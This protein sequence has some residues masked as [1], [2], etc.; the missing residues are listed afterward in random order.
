MQNFI[1]FLMV[2]INDLISYTSGVVYYIQYIWL[3]AVYLFKCR[4]RVRATSGDYGEV[5]FRLHPKFLHVMPA[6]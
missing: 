4:T 2:L 3:P 6:R 1:S 5:P